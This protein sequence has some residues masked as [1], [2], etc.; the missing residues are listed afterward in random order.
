MVFNDSFIGGLRY[1]LNETFYES[2]FVWNFIYDYEL[3]ENERPNILL[4]EVCERDID[5]FVTNKIEGK[6]TDF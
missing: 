1:L 5:L 2:L 6:E 3:I 4:H